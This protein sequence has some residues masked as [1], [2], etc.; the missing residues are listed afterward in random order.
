M[1]FIKTVKKEQRGLWGERA[2]RAGPGPGPR[3]GGW[4]MVCSKSV[5]TLVWNALLL[6][7][8]EYDGH[9]PMARDR[10]ESTLCPLTPFALLPQSQ[11]WAR[12][13]W[14]RV[15]QMLCTYGPSSYQPSNQPVN[16]IISSQPR[17]EPL[18][19]YLTPV[20]QPWYYMQLYMKLDRC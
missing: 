12:H 11:V 18:S 20:D 19:G 15:W 5:L 8:T 10:A 17:D 4:G 9:G 13:S 1:P 7:S 3:P 2:R 14:T 16:E 6:Y